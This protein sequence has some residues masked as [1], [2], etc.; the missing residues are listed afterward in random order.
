[1][2]APEHDGGA[3]AEKVLS[4]KLPKVSEL[5]TL[6]ADYVAHCAGDDAAEDE[7]WR[8]RLLRV[9]VSLSSCLATARARP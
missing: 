3:D 8:T 7:R 5:R 6:A 1:M 9:Q 4:E 2:A